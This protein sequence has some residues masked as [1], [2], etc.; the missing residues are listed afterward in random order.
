[1]TSKDQWT[2]SRCIIFIISPFLSVTNTEHQSKSLHS[3]LR[4]PLSWVSAWAQTV[5]SLIKHLTPSVGLSFVLRPQRNDQRT[6]PKPKLASHTELNNITGAAFRPPESW[7]W[8]RLRITTLGTLRILSSFP[9]SIFQPSC[10]CL[11]LVN[12]C[13]R[14]RRACKYSGARFNYGGLSASVKPLHQ[15]HVYC[16][17]LSVKRSTCE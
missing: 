17:C 1:M 2:S 15:H 16:V 7:R 6:I 3:C 9:D 4:A 5:R 8:N 12:M 10:V 11:F 14:F 13:H